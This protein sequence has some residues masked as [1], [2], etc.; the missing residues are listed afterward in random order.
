MKDSKGA[1]NDQVLD[2]EILGIFGK[3]QAVEQLNVNAQNSL[4]SRVMRTIDSEEHAKRQGIVTVRRTEGEWQNIGPRLEKKV[5]RLDHS[6]GT[7]EFL[8]RVGPGA[9]TPPHSHDHDELCMVMEGE[10]VINDIH[11]TAGDYHF[12]PKGSKHTVGRT[13]N[14]ALM[15][16]NTGYAAAASA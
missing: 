11:L 8:L 10:V 6:N 3:G 9:V 12:A 15:Y 5:L 7:E 1:D 13:K 2:D 4:D 16:F 14:G